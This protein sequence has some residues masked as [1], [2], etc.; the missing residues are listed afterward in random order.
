MMPSAERSN[1]DLACHRA[2]TAL[3]SERNGQQQVKCFTKGD[4]MIQHLPISTAFETTFLALQTFVV[5][6]LLFHDWVGLGRLNNL[7][8][9]RS[10][11]TL[12]HR[13]FV[14]LLPGV[15]AAIGLFLF[16]PTLSGLVGDITVDHLWRVHPRHA[17]CLVDTLSGST[18]RRAGSALSDYL[19]R[20][21]LVP[22]AAQWNG[23]GHA[24]YPV[25]SDHVGH[26]DLLFHE[27]A[28]DE[29]YLGR[30]ATPCHPANQLI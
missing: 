10:Q 21:P 18:R 14:T 20:H 17:P 5:A 16:Q 24:A 6:F 28:H 11:D 30:H 23:P 29:P 26:A 8:A 15:P 9:I 19:R 27:R 22:A 3:A 13:V 2:T 4:D 1:D 12:L 7:A 25:S